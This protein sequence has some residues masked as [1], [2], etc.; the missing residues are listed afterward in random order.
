MLN[1]GLI[2]IVF[3]LTALTSRSQE[4]T[5]PK[6]LDALLPISVKGCK[7]LIEKQSTYLKTDD[8]EISTANAVYGKKKVTIEIL[9]SDYFN[10]NL[11]FEKQQ[12][13]SEQ[14][15]EIIEIDNK[16]GNI[17]SDGEMQVFTL[18]WK[19]RYILKV[20]VIGDVNR[21]WVYGF[22]ESLELEKLQ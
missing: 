6:V 18:F 4:I 12:K 9:I 10:S 7:L 16:Q 3:L 2:Y 5:D 20:E 17:R 11:E 21:E 14:N 13:L 1:K 19:D 22:V 8:F 15:S